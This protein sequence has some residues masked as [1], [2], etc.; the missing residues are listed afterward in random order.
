MTAHSIASGFLKR[1]TQALERARALAE[2][3]PSMFAVTYASSGEKVVG[4]Q[5]LSI[6]DERYV[7]ELAEEGAAQLT[8]AIEHFIDPNLR[9]AVSSRTQLVTRWPLPT[10][11]PDEESRGSR[12]L[13]RL[14]L[15]LGESDADPDQVFGDV[16]WPGE[17]APQQVAEWARA[18]A[19]QFSAE[20]GGGGTWGD[21]LVAAAAADRSLPDLALKHDGASVH[22][23]AY[24]V[25]L[26]YLAWKDVET[27]RRRPAV[28]IDAARPHHDLVQG[29]RDT[30]KDTRKPANF[31]KSDGRIELLA[32]G[33]CVQLSLDL[34]GEERLS[35]ATIRVLRDWRGWMGL[36]NWAALQRLLSVE[37][38][39]EG[40]VRWTLDA[41]M[42]ALGYSERARLDPATR[43]RV[44][45]EVELFTKLE[46][47]VYDRSGKLRER[48][49]LVHV[50]T[51]FD[52]I[53]GARWVL[54]GMELRINPMLYQGVRDLRT[55]ELGS[56][57]GLAP[58]ELAQVD[59]VRHP[60]TIALGLVLPIRWRLSWADHRDH[61]R[62][63]GESLLRVAGVTY[64]RQ[65]AGRAWAALRRDLEELQRIGGLGRWEWESAPE[66]L[67]GIARLYPA[68]WM[69]DRIARGVTPLE[70]PPTPSVLTGSDLREWR[71]ARGL[72]QA[73]AAQMLGVGVATVKRAEAKAD[74]PV[75]KALRGALSSAAQ[76][77]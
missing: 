49:P 24:G 53:K 25:A 27:G 64:R 11:A 59:H 70:L 40:W 38:G 14:I 7:E 55:G 72:T 3:D 47:A 46:L 4:K 75:G 60:H 16:I 15:A 50:G 26:L 68:D 58:P 62:L 57:Y 61:V 37:G 77:R 67:T 13:L 51:K 63:S 21:E 8:H 18:A 73:I 45:D 19:N 69:L 2:N 39:R 42:A 29:W 66:T 20:H 23:P 22:L 54:D 43:A 71:E 34:P 32:P 9:P 65:A 35:E 30:P 36:R 52:R 33:R 41:H 56:N 76:G 17:A 31:R 12:A 10:H 48:R 44:A 1:L 6:F 5:A 28:A 74:E